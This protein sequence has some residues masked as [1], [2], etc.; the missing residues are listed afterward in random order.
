VVEIG[1]PEFPSL[2]ERGFDTGCLRTTNV[3]LDVITDHENLPG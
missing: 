2:Y 1:S 3:S